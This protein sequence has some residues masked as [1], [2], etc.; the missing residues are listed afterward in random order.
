MSTIKISKEEAKKLHAEGNEA[1]KKFL[2]DKFGKE[3]I[4]DNN[5]YVKV[6]EEFLKKFKL[7][8]ALP[9]PKDTTDRQEQRTNASHMLDHIVLAERGRREPDYDNPNEYKYEPIFNMSSS[10]FGFSYSRCDRW[11][12]GTTCGSR[13]CTFSDSECKRIAKK[14]I[15]IYAKKLT[16]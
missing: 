13:L 11:L 8:I 3:L 9:Y 1:V 5:D 4:E 12:T 2:E 16:K 7:D 15:S 14:Y 10:G 6:W